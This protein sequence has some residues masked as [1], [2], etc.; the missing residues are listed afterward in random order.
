MALELP[1]PLRSGALVVAVL[2]AAAGLNLSVMG[3]GAT[4]SVPEQAVATTA[5]TSDPEVRQVVV[6][7]PVPLNGT[8]ADLASATAPAAPV[9]GQT[10]P[11]AP[12]APAAA[13]TAAPLATAAPA[14]APPLTAAPATAPPPT[15]PPAT[16]APATA[17]PT[18]PP[19]T[20]TPTTAAPTTTAGQTTEYLFYTFDGVAEIV[21][22]YH[23]GQTLEFWSATTEDGWAF[24]VEKD[25]A[26]HIEVKFRRVSGRE[27][28]AK[29]ELIRKD[30]E[31]VV[32]KER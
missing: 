28:E 9:P 14:T 18:L 26:S 6:D 21:V 5:L 3:I 7:V 30:G 22:A 29:F 1:I 27:G 23:D 24:M 13:P 16:A 19:S 8:V 10:A 4:P 2:G 31:L 12:P 15:A 11:V 25:S 20:A 17:A 32:K